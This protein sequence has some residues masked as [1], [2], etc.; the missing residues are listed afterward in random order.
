MTRSLTQ[1]T[2]WHVVRR[3]V[4]NLVQHASALSLSLPLVLPLAL[5]RALLLPLALA[6]A[7]LP[8]HVLLPLPPSMSLPHP[9]S[10]A[11][12]LPLPLAPMLA[13]ALSQ[14]Q[15][16]ARC[17]ALVGH[18]LPHNYWPIGQAAPRLCEPHHQDSCLGWHLCRH[19][20]C[21]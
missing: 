4:L 17:K 20:C 2:L 8:P 16:V 7:L 9:L 10:L 5:A 13:L 21:C 12:A 14:P 3:M 18:T 6:L 11:Y 19:R 15:Q 1:C